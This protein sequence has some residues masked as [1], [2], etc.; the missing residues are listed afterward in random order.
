MSACDHISPSMLATAGRCLQQVYYFHILKLKLPPGVA[1][2]YGSSLHKTLLELDQKNRIDTG[3]YKPLE[4]LKEHFASDFQTRLQLVDDTDPEI[5][6]YGGKAATNAAYEKFAFGTLEKYNENRAILDGRGVEVP[7]EVPFA[8]TKLTG[9]IDLDVSDSAF[10]D[11]KTKDLTRK[12]SK[13]ATQKD[14]DF[15]RQFSAYAAAK[16]RMTRQPVQTL[17]GVFFYKNQ[18]PEIGEI[19]SFRDEASHA[20]IESIA[21]KLKTI[22]E[23]DAFVPVDKTSQAGWVCQERY[24]GAWKAFGRKDGFEGCPYGERSRVSVGLTKEEP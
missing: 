17:S 18:K 11:V 10:K 23:H 5:V 12:T 15:S 1:Q 16:A 14:V 2:S 21:F 6:Q 20:E 7:F 22:I 19:T 4:E 9:Y 24:C 3:A 13:R 8:D